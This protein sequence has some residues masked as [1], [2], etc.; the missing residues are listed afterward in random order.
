MNPPPRRFSGLNA[1]D[2][3]LLLSKAAVTKRT[4][5]IRVWETT[6]GEMSPGASVIRAAPALCG[7]FVNATMRRPE[8]EEETHRRL[9]ALRRRV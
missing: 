4:F 9:T 1:S 6:A 3:E 5:H 8:G 2:V 7:P